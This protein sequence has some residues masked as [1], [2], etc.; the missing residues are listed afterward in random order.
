VTRLNKRLQVF[1]Y[2]E[3]YYNRKRIHPKRGYLSPVTF[4]ENETKK[5]L[6]GMSMYLG[7]DQISLIT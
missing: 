5:S 1:E 3:V 4:E 6:S 7:Q 2:I